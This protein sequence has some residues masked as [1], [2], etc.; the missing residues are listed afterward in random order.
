MKLSVI[1]I[2]FTLLV[3]SGV[4]QD[5]DFLERW[6]LGFPVF[7]KTSSLYKYGISNSHFLA[8]GV[9]VDTSAVFR[10]DTLHWA[11]AVPRDHP[12][13]SSDL[14]SA[15]IEITIS[16]RSTTGLDNPK[17]HYSGPSRV[18]TVE[19]FLKSYDSITCWI[20]R[21]TRKA[22]S[23]KH[24]TESVNPEGGP[25]KYSFGE[26]LFFDNRKSYRVF[27]VYGNVYANGKTS[28]LVSYEFER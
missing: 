10:L 11:Q 3:S 8:V 27:S 6:F 21:I 18:V 4:A 2:V 26:I 9:A 1:T 28:L 7:D 25:E 5:R 13:F 12:I 17:Q 14:D 22:L 15:I 16:Y 20:D 23:F 19:Y 24:L